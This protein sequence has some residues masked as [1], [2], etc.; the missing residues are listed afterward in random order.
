MSANAK[1]AAVIFGILF[2]IVG[3]LGFIP[4]PIVSPT[5]I[6]EVNNYH[7]LFHIGAGILL[8]VGA[9]ASAGSF[10]PGM[11]LRFVGAVYAVLAVMGFFMPMNGILGAFAMNMA[12]H[13]LH[14]LLA[15]V[16][17]LAGFV[18]APAPRTATT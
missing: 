9:Y 2:L 6:F 4:N 1:S 7:N 18:L 8:L 16:L 12:D 15:V 10:G 13:W 11:A 5:G 17:L 14:T 3:V